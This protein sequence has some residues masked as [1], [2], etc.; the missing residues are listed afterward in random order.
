M[1]IKKITERQVIGSFYKALAQNA[2]AE[3][4]GDV[5]N[6]FTS[7]QEIEEYAWLGMTPAMREWIG[8][9][10]TKGF[11]EE[12]MQIRNKHYEATLEVLVKDLRRDK[13]GQLMAR[14]NEQARRANT[15]WASLLASLI[16]DGESSVCYDGQ[17]FFDTD[18][19][20]GDS[21]A[22]SNNILVDISA[23]PV[24]IHG[25]TTVP[26]VAEFQ[27][28]IAKG[29]EQIV[30]FVDDQEEPMNEDA[31]AFTIMVPIS[32]M[33]V[34]LQAAATPTQVGE[35]QTV[36]QA[37]KSNFSLKVVPTPRLASWNNK[38]AMFRTDTYLKSLIR[39]EEMGV[40]MK[41]KG[42]GSEFEFD[43]DAH[44]YGIDCWRNVGFGYWQNSCLI[45]FE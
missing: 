23:L 39:Q 12:S 41:V 43:N 33:N 15:H 6:Y 7:D 10:N 35:T 38:F 22:Q 26:A 9:R 27:H 3:W 42:Q 32:F 29:V 4:I 14:I 36:L 8:G 45:T 21:G 25:S 30:S 24:E 37:L 28:A 34:A 11:R 2:G 16:V 44:Q 17:Y 20:E 18:H 1:G 5:S 19:E 31:T 13:T 40:K